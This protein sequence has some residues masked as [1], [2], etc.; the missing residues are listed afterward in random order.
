[1]ESFFTHNAL[2]VVLLVALTVWLGI[3]FYINRLENKVSILEQKFEKLMP[4]NNEK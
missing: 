3:A 4:K 1:M 2:Y